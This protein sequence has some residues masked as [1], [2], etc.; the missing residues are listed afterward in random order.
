MLTRNYPQTLARTAAEPTVSTAT[1]YYL[2]NIGKVTSVSQLMG[3]SR[4]YNYVLN[5]FGLSDMSYAKGLITKVIEG[6]TSSSSSLANKLNDSRYKELANAFNY[7]TTGGQPTAAA[8]T[9]VVNNYVEQTVETQAG[10][11]ST[12]AQMA[13]YFQRMAPTITSAYNILADKTLLSVVQTALGLSTNSSQASIDL[14]AKAI[15]AKLD[16]SSLQDPAKLQQFIGRFTAMYDMKNGDT[17]TATPTNALLVSSTG[18]SS[19]LLLSLSKLQLGG[20]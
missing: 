16:I 9:G 6:G 3:N 14:Q 5:A 4:L 2:A 1:D 18:I 20:N 8:T 7:L 17:S 10:Q 19:N 12:G 11:Q 13:L 15:S